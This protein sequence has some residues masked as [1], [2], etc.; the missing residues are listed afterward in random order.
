MSIRNPVAV[1]PTHE[2]TNTPPHM[3][4]QDLWASDLA[5][6]EGTTRE[7]AAWAE[8][9]LAAFGK[10]AGREDVL[11]QAD[12]ANRF[13]PELK[14]FDRYGMRVNQVSF[15]P[16]YHALQDLAVSNGLPNFAWNNAGAG[17]HV[18][19]AALNYMLNQI[20]GGVLCP[21][22]MTYAAIPTLKASPA[23]AEEWLPKLLS[24]KYDKRDIPVG[25][26]TGAQMGMFMTE[27][28]GGSDVRANTTRA[29]RD[30]E[31]YRL[32]GHK[33]FC[34]APM[35]DAFLTLAYAEAGLSCFLIPRFQ[36]DGQRNGLF[37]QRLK[38]KLGNTSNASSEMELQNTWGLLV[39][40]EGKGIKTIIEMV[41][42]TRFYCA[43]GS[44]ALMR[45]GLVQALHHTSHRSAFQ[46]RLIDQPLMQNVL[47]D[48][49]LESEAATT[50]SL[51][52]GRA[53]DEAEAGNTEAA[54][55]ARIGTA[56]GKYWIC[57]RAPN[58]TYE[59]MEC[60]GGPGYV[61]ESIMP[62]LYREAPVNSIWE[63]SGNVICL[64]VLRALQRD[65]EAGAA[66]LSEVE[67]ARVGN[68]H[69]DKSL[70]DLKVALADTSDIEL[71]ARRLTEHMALVWQAALLVKHAPAPVSDAFCASRLGARW[72]GSYGTLPTGVDC[73]AIVQRARGIG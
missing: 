56:I 66:F 22:A 17:G 33:F 35:S 68:S 64:D 28:Q 9:Q 32:T 16:S 26:K 25:E 46:K 4:D 41:Q 59:A 13:G 72:S 2:V 34:S 40:P 70:D 44:A 1:L 5:L 14:P 52:L 48:L 54:A 42:G 31:G 69:F 38:D 67:S 29:T 45:Q 58:H 15:H 73:G 51:R 39:G 30:G 8:P 10:A 21:I 23:I 3:G 37:L 61:E 71:R 53:I 63:G 36:P 12:Q 43:F 65:P 55:L 57:K 6:R 7:G 60:H 19:H 11:E 50:L 20:E 18:A 27:K 24:T 49:A 47:A 62:R